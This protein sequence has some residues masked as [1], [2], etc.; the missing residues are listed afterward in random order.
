MIGRILLATL[1]ALAAGAAPIALAMFGAWTVDLGTL[2]G[3]DRFLVGF[4]A[5][6]LG[7]VAFC[8]SFAALAKIG[9]DA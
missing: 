8:G 3:P 9:G 2:A 5:L 4:L 7:C 1:A 6:A